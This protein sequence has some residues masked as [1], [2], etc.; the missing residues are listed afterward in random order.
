MDAPDRTRGA[1]SG[2]LHRPVQRQAAGTG[3]EEGRLAGRKKQSPTPSVGASGATATSLPTFEVGRGEEI[4][5]L[6]RRDNSPL[7]PLP[8]PCF[9]SF[10]ALAALRAA[11]ESHAKARA[12]REGQDE[13]TKDETPVRRKRRS[14]VER[15]EAQPR[16]GHVSTCAASVCSPQSLHRARKSGRSTVPRGSSRSRRRARQQVES[17]ACRVFESTP[18]DGGTRSN[19]DTRPK[20]SSKRADSPFCDAGEGR[21][22][23][24]VKDSASPSSPPVAEDCGFSCG[25]TLRADLSP[26]RLSLRA[27]ARSASRASLHFADLAPGQPS[28]EGTV[29]GSA[30][31]VLPPDVQASGCGVRSVLLC[32][33]S[34]LCRRSENLNSERAGK[35]SEGV[36]CRSSSFPRCGRSQSQRGSGARPRFWEFGGDCTGGRAKEAVDELRRR[37]GASCLTVRMPVASSP[38]QLSLSSRS[39]LVPAPELPS[40]LSSDEA[41]A[42]QAA[43]IETG[44]VPGRPWL[45]PAAACLAELSP[46][47][48]SSPLPPWPSSRLQAHEEKSTSPLAHRC[49][50]EPL[51]AATA[52]STACLP[53][54][55]SAASVVARD[56]E[57]E[58]EGELRLSTRGGGEPVERLPE[59]GGL[60]EDSLGTAGVI[61]NEE[62]RRLLCAASQEARSECDVLQERLRKLSAENARRAAALRPHDFKEDSSL[63]RPT[64][65]SPEGG[66]VSPGLLLCAPRRRRQAGTFSSRDEALSTPTLESLER[67]NLRI[68]S[69]PSGSRPQL[70]GRRCSAACA[71]PSPEFS[72]PSVSSR[73]SCGQ[74]LCVP[75][76]APDSIGDDEGGRASFL[77]RESWGR[78]WQEESC[79][80]SCCP[81]CGDASSHPCATYPHDGAQARRRGNTSFVPLRS[82]AA[83]SG[84]APFSL[85]HASRFMPHA[86]EAKCREGGL[87]CH[88]LDPSLSSPAQQQQQ[89]ALG[90]GSS[91]QA[92]ASVRSSGPEGRSASLAAAEN[93]EQQWDYSGFRRRLPLASSSVEGSDFG[94]ITLRRSQSDELAARASSGSRG[95]GREAEACVRAYQSTRRMSPLCERLHTEPHDERVSRGGSEACGGET[96]ASARRLERGSGGGGALRKVS[97]KNPP[98]GQ[99]EG[100]CAAQMSNPPSSQGAQNGFRASSASS[101]SPGTSR[102]FFGRVFSF[103]RRKTTRQEVCE[104][105]CDASNTAAISAAEIGTCA[106]G[107][108]DMRG[109][110]A[111]AAGPNRLATYGGDAGFPK[112]DTDASASFPARGPR[113]NS[114]RCGSDDEGGSFEQTRGVVKARE[115]GSTAALRPA[116]QTKWL[117]ALSGEEVRRGTW[118]STSTRTSSQTRA[119]RGGRGAVH[120]SSPDGFS[121]LS[122]LTPESFPVETAAPLE[123]SPWA[124]TAAFKEERARPQ[125][126]GDADGGASAGHCLDRVLWTPNLEESDYCCGSASET[127]TQSFGRTSG[128]GGGDGEGLCSSFSVVKNV[129]KDCP[130]CRRQVL[131]EVLRVL[132][133][134]GKDQRVGCAPRQRRRVVRAAPVQP[135]GFCT[136][137]VPKRDP[138]DEGGP[139]FAGDKSASLR[140]E[141][142]V[143][144]AAETVV[145][146]SG[147]YGS[148]F[149]KGAAGMRPLSSGSHMEAAPDRPAGSCFEGARARGQ[150][151]LRKAGERTADSPEEATEAG[152]W[153]KAMMLMDM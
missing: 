123:A 31:A 118:D 27:K 132:G 145:D 54:S 137:W 43:G 33:W 67:E 1:E 20:T 89:H 34:G 40:S 3:A 69:S 86:S 122:C 52:A 148:A 64:D 22:C 100:E 80:G 15:G 121:H 9:A 124:P 57:G 18:L 113:E 110:V 72:V 5:Y 79:L 87:S 66:G 125:L 32:S 84:D 58:G 140:E 17:D 55:A 99:P 77:R 153:V 94:T 56:L 98:E 14:C 101:T 61:I 29:E 95:C 102:G 10:A 147:S 6:F 106:E 75:P 63:C 96:E 65:A 134:A 90:L 16:D 78:A 59:A 24:S 88:S 11:V 71:P 68:F 136:C 35:R 103:L 74:V 143:V 108:R 70:V 130:R 39:S 129:A 133:G 105:V 4:G 85:S 149:V 83:H 62:L 73:Q 45:A 47:G 37:C 48:P 2:A 112:A 142:G 146:S 8:P 51:S 141:R 53:S 97:G 7:S 93:R 131:L 13:E 36:N 44:Q 46:S 116:G 82:V 42:V 117:T 12:G 128:R 114:T 111:R 21:F 104:G 151:A 119:S 38:A 50:S 28:R 25:T 109:A 76:S 115:R 41:S 120:V 49:A 126:A 81:S 19:L 60:E 150:E 92:A 152:L 139:T 127:G 91:R 23:V 135:L 138:R 26:L 107:G 144:H 30:G